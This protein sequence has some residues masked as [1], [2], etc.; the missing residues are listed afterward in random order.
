MNRS[1]ALLKDIAWLQVAFTISQLAT[2]SRRQVGCVLLDKR[3]RVI[4][5]GYNGVAPDRPHCTEHPCGGAHCA[6]GTG[7]DLCEAIHAE[8]NAL[9]QCKFPD[10][11][12][13]VYCTDSPCIHCAKL[14]AGTGAQR[15]VFGRAYPHSNSEEYWTRQGR[16][17]VHIPTTELGVGK[18]WAVA[19][20]RKSL[21]ESIVA[22][23][24]AK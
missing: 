21:V 24:D 1:R 5:T 12:H 6:S 10:D 20:R 9:I 13:T 2:C 14:L 4:G 18:R 7:L 19:P 17:W 15:I 8:Q 23:L 3:G 16:T 22:W 11:I